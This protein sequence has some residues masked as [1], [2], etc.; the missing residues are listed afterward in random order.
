VTSH[1]RR[2]LGAETDLHTGDVV[3]ALRIA[4]IGPFGMGPKGTMRRRALPLAQELAARGHHVKMLL[5][6]W[7]TPG[8][9]GRVWEERGV[10]IENVSLW[11]GRAPWLYPCVTARLVRGALSWQP[12]VIHC[13]KPK[14]YAGWSAWVVWHAK[15]LGTARV[16]LVVDE[17][18]WEGPGGWNDLE[19]YSCA[20]RRTFAW[21]ERW[22]LSHCEAV[23]VASRALQ[24]LVWG[25]AV[26]P[27]R[28]YYLPNGVEPSVAGDGA[29]VR[30]RHGLGSA[31]VILLYTRFFEYDVARVVEALARIRQVMPAARLLIVGQALHPQDGQRFWRLAQEAGQVSAIVDAGWVEQALLP[32][33]FAAADVALF[34]FDDT[35]V[36]RCKCSVKLLDLLSAGAPVVAEAVGQNAEYVRHGETGMLVESG[37]AAALAQATLALLRDRPLAQR[38]GQAAAGSLRTRYGWDTLVDRLLAAYGND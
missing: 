1:R 27:E 31:A 20:L 15:R 21:Q 26:P 12:D 2:A 29:R 33:Y 9:A 23:T 10:R 35:L 25:L 17:D 19:P 32:D 8:E 4:M 22:G 38:L 5:P 37:D 30:A 28:V 6:P 34:P 36:N 11:P 18:D 13:F 7:H 16:R 3:S 24:S 14:A